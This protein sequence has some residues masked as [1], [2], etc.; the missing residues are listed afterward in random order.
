[1]N[2]RIKKIRKELH[3]T[4]DDLANKLNVSKNFIWMIEKGD[5]LPS[6]RTVKDLCREFGINE[7]WLRTG[8]GQMIEPLDRN[9]EIA[10]LVAN[11]KK[12]PDSMKSKLTLLLQQ[13][14]DDTIALMY[15]IAKQ[16]VNEVEGKDDQ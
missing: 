7:N 10:R 8:E 5:R 9:T 15:D 2:E 4:Q 1:M 11:M 14:D 16:W 13:V 12:T 6:D 3:L